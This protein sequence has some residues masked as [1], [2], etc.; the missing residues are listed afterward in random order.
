MD[1]TLSTINKCSATGKTFYPTP[2]QAKEA[3]IKIKARAKFFN[4][5]TRKRIK[6]RGGKPQQCRYYYCK[7]C[8]GYHLTSMEAAPYEKSIAKRIEERNK[9]NKGLVI[10][11][12]EAEQWKQDS[13]PFPEINQ[14]QQQHDSEELV[15]TQ[16]GQNR[17]AA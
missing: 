17:N 2:G 16:R 9:S 4:Y 13:L 1:R 11:P 12:Q 8:R 7:F 6:H 5:N 14:N 15:Q 3:M 10:S